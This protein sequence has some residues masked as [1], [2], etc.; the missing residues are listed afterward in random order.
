MDGAWRVICLCAAWC[1][2]CRD[3]RAPFEA[4]AAAHPQVRFDWVDIEDEADAL[5]EVDVET[6]PTVLIAQGGLAR[7][8][9]PVLPSAAQLDRLLT[10]LQADGSAAATLPAEAGLLLAR[11]QAGVLP[12]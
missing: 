7:F 11:L 9:G 10:S 3:W 8:Y 6:F 4:A 1:S 2:A 5:G 12:R